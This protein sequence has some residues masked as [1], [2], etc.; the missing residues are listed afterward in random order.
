[1]AVINFRMLSTGG[2]GECHVTVL[3]RHPSFVTQRH[4]NVQL[5]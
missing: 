4:H 5:D 1:M 2:Q 3:L